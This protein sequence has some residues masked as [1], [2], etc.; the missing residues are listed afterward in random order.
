MFGIV[1]GG[2]SSGREWIE[3]K[4]AFPAFAISIEVLD[5]YRLHLGGHKK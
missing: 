3:V 2:C 4:D 5:G 1:S